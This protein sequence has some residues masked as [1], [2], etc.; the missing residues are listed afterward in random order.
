MS[1]TIY[2]MKGTPVRRLAL[3]NQ[4]AGY[5]A[6]RGKAAY[7]DGRNERGETVASG[8]YIYQ[9]R[10]GDYAASRRMVIVK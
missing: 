1:I 5:Y 10:A 7:W 8:I 2:D 9:F 4:A 3:G 6:A